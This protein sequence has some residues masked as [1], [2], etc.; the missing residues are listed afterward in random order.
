[1]SL[2]RCLLDNKDALADFDTESLDAVVAKKVESGMSQTEAEVS[3]IEEK[4]QELAD[5]EA[6]LDNEILSQYEKSDPK[7]FKAATAP[8]ESTVLAQA[9]GHGYAGTDV[10]EAVTWEELYAEMGAD[11]MSEEDRLARAREM[12][13]DTST[14]WYHGTEGDSFDAFDE[15][16]IGSSTKVSTPSFGPQGFY[17]TTDRKLAESHAGENGTVM[18]V[19]LRP[20]KT[21]ENDLDAMSTLA[22]FRKFNEGQG[23]SYRSIAGD[24]MVIRNARDIRDIN[25]A[26][27]PEQSDSPNLLAQD[28]RGEI[29]LRDNGERVIRLTNAADASTFIHEAAHLFLEAERQFVADYGISE[30]QKAIMKFL[31]IES[32][33]ELALP[34]KATDAQIET[35]R[36]KHEKFAETFEDYVR[37]GNAPSTAL[38]DAF[39]ALARWMTRIYQSI[40]ANSAL[41]KD[42]RAMFDRLLATQ[43]QIEEAATEPLWSQLFRSKEQA[44][45]TDAQWKKYKELQA[46][47][48]NRA[49]TTLYEKVIKQFTARKKKEWNTERAP[50]VEFEM[51]RLETQ[52]EYAVQAEMKK[53]PVDSALIQPYLVGNPKASGK[54]IK[55]RGEGGV[56]PEV[57]AEQHG[58]KSVEEMVEAVTNTKALKTA[59]TE[60][61][62]KIMIKKHGDIFNDGSLEAEVRNA[63]HNDIEARLLLTELRQIAKRTPRAP[64]LD[65]KAIRADARNMVATMTYS[66]I[67][68]DKY[69]RAEVRA[70]TN[71]GKAKTPTEAFNFKMEQMVNHY[72]YKEATIAKRKAMQYRAYAQ[73]VK[74]RTYRSSDVDPEYTQ[75]MKELVML[76]NLKK[77]A[78]RNKEATALMVW[79]AGQ[80]T[81]GA[82]VRLKDHNLLLLNKANEVG[83][84]LEFTMPSFDELTM[85]QLRSMYEQLRHLRAIGGRSARETRAELVAERGGLIE[86]LSELLANKGPQKPKTDWEQSA[87]STMQHFFHQIP[88][89]RNMIRDVDKGE[90]GPFFDALYRRIWRA[91]TKKMNIHK[92]WMDQLDTVMAKVNY[93]D[94]NDSAKSRKT[95]P[96]TDFSLTSRERVALA[97]YWG[98]ESS[99]EA[100]RQGHKVTDEQVETMLSYLPD[101]HLQ[102]VNDI[103]AFHEDMAVDLFAA[104]IELEGEAPDK[105]PRVPFKVNGVEMTGGHHRLF[106]SQFPEKTRL[107]QDPLLVAN[108]VVPSKAGSLEARVGSGGRKVDMSL[109]NIFRNLEENS[110]FVGY[111][112]IARELNTVYNSRDVRS[113]VSEVYGK[114]FEKALYDNLQGLTT[115]LKERAENQWLAAASR[116]IRGAASN[117]YLAWN[118]RNIIQQFG[119]WIPISA[120]VGPMNYA[121]AVSTFAQDWSGNKAFVDSMSE[122]MRQRDHHL[123]REHVDMMK[124][125][126]TG[127]KLEDSMNTLAQNGF[128]P[129]VMIDQTFAYPMWLHKYNEQYEMHGDKEKAAIAADIVV[130]ETVG[131]GLDINVGKFYRAN[132]P[133]LHKLIGLFGSWFNSTVFQR[134]Y[135]AVKGGNPAATAEALF[136][137]PFLTAIFT[138]AI[139]MDAPNEDDEEGLAA[140][141]TKK[142][143]SF[144]GAT[145]PLASMALSSIMGFT[146]RL[147]PATV[148]SNIGRVAEI[149][150]KLYNDELTVTEGAYDV[151]VLAGSVYPLPG[152]GNVTRPLQYLESAEKGNEDE[153][154]TGLDFL[155]ELYQ[156]VAEGSDKNR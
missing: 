54:F 63:M 92:Q 16:L 107:D 103:W 87:S 149:P 73:G 150:E 152:S 132:E 38:R 78:D 70:A 61:A 14:V 155:R 99:R 3:A 83:P 72:L 69:Y 58:F 9:V 113:L 41:D 141:M 139:V 94:I 32:F 65:V 154:E 13:F 133:E 52:P 22:T 66:E 145:I 146:P 31:E 45:M 90:S 102:L 71:A 101:E 39:A 56:D 27:D 7:G 126:K 88:T 123:N 46:K 105:I 51:E 110:H 147:L 75:K 117:M 122:Q 144:M 77:P 21:L 26:F 151:L 127:S 138:A 67:K 124:K 1:M 2:A 48:N 29:E 60:S 68:P 134:A 130:A 89:L 100:I 8:R 76:Y 57:Y 44:G 129:H 64:D 53:E 95:V 116:W 120:E 6:T 131:S 135:K 62:Q 47:R 30:N 35:W 114:G 5:S 12:G 33:D 115:N 37:E 143:V 112:G 23:D 55:L 20:G 79:M 18:E 119:A 137:T 106:Y 80:V 10:K 136:L 81:G 108:S 42:A 128:K 91:D 17:F 4:L 109:D 104:A 82:N 156:S 49:E 153:I 19:Y 24:V 74:K 140:W 85:D 34:P 98:E 50:I 40:R 93:T 148:F 86:Y 59:A 36:A 118:V 125:V 97:L 15:K 121:N 43:E 142:Y 25:S 28:R 111:A 11:A 84:D 96:G